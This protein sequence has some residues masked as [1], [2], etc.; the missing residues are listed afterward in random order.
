MSHANL[1]AI[2]GCMAEGRSEKEAADASHG[3]SL[4]QGMLQ[5][6]PVL[7]MERDSQGAT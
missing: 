4:P 6:S 5:F 2:V 3:G 7:E 1:Q